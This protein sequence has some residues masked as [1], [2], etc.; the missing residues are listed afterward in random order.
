MA[1][2]IRNDYGYGLEA[3]KTLIGR[4][5]RF[6][7]DLAG[8]CMVMD[9]LDPADVGIMQNANDVLDAYRLLL[10]AARSVSDG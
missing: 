1:R 9:A 6:E 3:C 4:G 8:S 7:Y 2:R 10:L 5:A